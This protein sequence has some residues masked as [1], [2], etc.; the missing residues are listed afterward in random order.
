[1]YMIEHEAVGMHEYTG[2]GGVCLQEI[3]A[4]G[5]EDDV[6]EGRLAIQVAIVMEQ[7]AP[8]VL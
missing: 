8:A 6:V 4:V 7:I 1:M 5:S 3:H 2:G